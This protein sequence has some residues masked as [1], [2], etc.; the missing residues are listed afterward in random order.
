MLSRHG[1]KF[2]EERD[3]CLETLNDLIDDPLLLKA[4]A[5]KL[6]ERAGQEAK[7]SC[8]LDFSDH[9]LIRFLRARDFDVDLAF[10][11]G[12]R[13]Q[14]ISKSRLIRLFF[15]FLFVRHGIL[16]GYVGYA[17]FAI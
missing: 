1:M 17:N 7:L 13:K 9:F 10:K 6:R 2:E 15:V 16:V 4:Y 5:S 14:P 8:E 3:G 12:M 11:V